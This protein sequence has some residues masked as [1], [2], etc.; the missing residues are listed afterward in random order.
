MKRVLGEIMRLLNS[1]LSD[2]TRVDID[3]PHEFFEGSQVL[4]LASVLRSA[5]AELPSAHAKG[6]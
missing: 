3:T 5:L 2:R 4:W 6:Q 1:D